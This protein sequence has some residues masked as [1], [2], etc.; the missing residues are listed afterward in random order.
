MTAGG[1]VT[2]K[3][4]PRPISLSTRT[5]PPSALKMPLQIQS[6]RPVPS[7]AGLV[8]K[9]GSRI[10]S[11]ISS[12]IPIPLSRTSTTARPVPS[13]RVVTRISLRS[14]SPSGMACAALSSR[15]KKTWPRRD[16]FPSTIGV[17]P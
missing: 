2:R 16:S 1:S 10:R 14:V 17:S 4:L 7:L 11:R 15:F 9:K 8:V 5:S 3:V 12:G 13:V 6:P